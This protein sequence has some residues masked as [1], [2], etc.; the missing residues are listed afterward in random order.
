[1][2][3]I[4]TDFYSDDGTKQYAPNIL[5]WANLH[6]EG[7]EKFGKTTNIA[8]NLKQWMIDAGF[9]NVREEV[10]KVCLSLSLY[11]Q[12]LPVIKVPTNPWAKDPK[13]KE[14]AR[15]HLVNLQESLEAYSLALLTRV[16]GMSYE[17]VQVFFADV[18]KEL[19]DRSL[20]L[21]AKY[22]FVFGQKEV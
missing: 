3:D 21:Y 5:R 11:G 6:N 15:F 12:Y 18:R 2:A 9:K 22:Y 8:P 19:A 14:L 20:H 7:G 4:A 1:M 16:L 13:L 10:Y 17:E